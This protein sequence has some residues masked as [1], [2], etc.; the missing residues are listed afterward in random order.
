MTTPKTDTADN[1]PPKSYEVH[2]I[3]NIFPRLGETEINTLADDIKANGLRDP[4]WLYEGKILDGVNRVEACKR[5]E[6]EVRAWDYTGNDPIGFVLSV[7]LHRRHLDASQRAMVAAKLANLEVGANQSTPG[8][9]IGVAAE[10][11]NVGRGS[12]DRA[13]VVLKSGDAEIVKAVETG[14]IPVSKAADQVKS[15]KASKKSGATKK[16]VV[17][18]PSTQVSDDADVLVDKLIE[19]LREMKA[20]TREALLVG[21]FK[22][23]RDFGYILDLPDMAIETEQEDDEEEDDDDD[24]QEAA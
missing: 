22:R 6:V 11:L 16:K 19:A 13:R 4:I 3:A 15:S 24:E 12:I 18:P 7:N 17:T 1:N 10:L 20:E 21:M 2:P 8:T 14:E 5:A 23:F 9:P